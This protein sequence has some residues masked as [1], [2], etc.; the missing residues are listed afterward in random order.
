MLRDSNGR[1]RRLALMA[2]L[3]AIRG[4]CRA[5]SNPF[6]RVA[7]ISSLCTLVGEEAIPELARLATDTNVSVRKAAAYHLG[8]MGN[9]PQEGL[10]ALRRLAGDAALDVQAAAQEALV[11]CSESPVAVGEARGGGLAGRIFPDELEGKREFLLS[12]IREWQESLA[13]NFEPGRAE[14]FAEADRALGVLIGE[15]EG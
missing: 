14:E 3:N 5:D 8:E 13:R 7:A 12:A 9:L 15:L 1:I 11:K 6:I 2:A 10:D 4:I